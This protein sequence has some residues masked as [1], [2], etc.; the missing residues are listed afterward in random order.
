[1]NQESQPS[2]TATE[3]GNV[4]AALAR[5][6]A[7][8]E[9]LEAG[10]APA[11]E[12]GEAAPATVAAVF[13]SFD[14]RVS[15]LAARGINV[16]ERARRLAGLFEQLSDPAIIET[17][18]Q[19]LELARSVPAGVSTAADVFD[20]WVARLSVAGV[21]VDQRMSVLIRVAERL[22]APEALDVVC[23]LL[24]HTETI[25]RLLKS[26]VFEAGAVNAVARAADALRCMDLDNVEPVGALGALKALGDPDVKKALGALVAF[27]QCFGR[28]AHRATD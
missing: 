10:L 18:E 23:E 21:D 4:L 11:L 9:R 5:I 6:E 25:A 3:D 8:L 13:D 1:M 15:A 19:S 16:D 20:G 26:G 24:A 2:K 22:T 7:R 12:L 17:V 28:S 27:G 14:A